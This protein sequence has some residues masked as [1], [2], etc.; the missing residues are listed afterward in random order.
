MLADP[1]NVHDPSDRLTP[2]G[3]RLRSVAASLAY[4]RDGPSQ[5]FRWCP[6]RGSSGDWL[7]TGTQKQLWVILAS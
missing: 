5:S 2:A 3:L 6:P 1:G 4:T 7:R